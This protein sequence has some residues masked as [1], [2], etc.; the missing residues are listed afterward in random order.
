MQNYFHIGRFVIPMYYSFHTRYQ[1]WTGMMAWLIKYLI[2]VLSM[3]YVQ[4]DFD[5]SRFVVGL[6]FFYV[7]Y[8][9][10]YIQN[11]CETIKKEAS[12]TLRLKADELAFYESHK[13]LIYLTRLAELLLLGYAL[14]KMGV[15]MAI[16]LYGTLT[17]LIFAWYNTIRNGF[18]LVVHLIL[19]MLRYTF[20]VFAASNHFSV[21]V[22]WVALILY[23]LTL[24]I[25]R[26][27]KGKFEYKSQWL[28]R[29]VM[30]NYDERYLFR[31]R[32]YSVLL[33]AIG[34]WILC[35]WSRAAYGFPVLLL[36]ATSLM[37]YRSEKYRYKH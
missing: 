21:E 19:M 11:D 29:F 30:H 36:W 20:P 16:L 35:D 34:I 5:F 28:A 33:V 12:P 4:A 2:P 23:P 10:G 31:L 7:I 18:C 37:N 32:Y 26:S 8:E 27:V 15:G 3:A 25:E 17:L 9:V 13:I 24:F 1:G 14:T 6:L 22:A